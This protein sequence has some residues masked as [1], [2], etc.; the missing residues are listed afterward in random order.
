MT[1]MQIIIIFAWKRVSFF[2][3]FLFSAWKKV[4][5]WWSVRWTQH[6]CVERKEQFSKCLQ[7]TK[8]TRLV[9]ASM[10][11]CPLSERTIRTTNKL[12]LL[13]RKA[14]TRASASHRHGPMV[15][16]FFR[17]SPLHRTRE[18]EREMM[19]WCISNAIPETTWSAFVGT[20]SIFFSYKCHFNG[21]PAWG[22]VPNA[23]L[24]RLQKSMYRKLR[25]DFWSLC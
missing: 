6:K 5:K 18:R 2:M 1:W 8:N 19:S 14:Y 9:M 23:T 4:P 13:S 22:L 17:V 10:M 3:I 25:C 15:C 7:N 12:R 21:S 16:I 11:T 20:F 24:T